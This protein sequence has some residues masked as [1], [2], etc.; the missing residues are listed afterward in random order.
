[1]REQDCSANNTAEPHQI[2]RRP[3]GQ[4]GGA[5]RT[6]IIK[7]RDLRIGTWNKGGANQDLRKKINEIT[8]L[9]HQHK[10]DCLGVTE[11][12]LKK[13]ANLEEVNIPG[14]TI[15]S[16]MGIKNKIKKN[17]RVVAYVK[18]ELSYKV[19]TKTHWRGPNA[20][21]LV[22]ARACRNKKNSCWFYT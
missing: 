6:R 8:I 7:T 22:E 20:R 19:V 3:I 16:D 4:G 2:K 15:F 9:L 5:A 11:A 17:S 21:D 10:L 1:M 14:Y 12:N 18:D 13:E